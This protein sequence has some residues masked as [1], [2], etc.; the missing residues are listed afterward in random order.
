[1]TA[2]KARRAFLL[3]RLRKEGP[4][5]EALSSVL[6]ATAHHQSALTWLMHQDDDYSSRPRLFSLLFFSS[7][8]TSPT[9]LKLSPS[10]HP[11]HQCLLSPLPLSSH[12][13]V[14]AMSTSSTVLCWL[15]WYVTCCS[16]T[17]RHEELTSSNSS[18][19]RMKANAEHVPQDVAAEYYGQRATAGGLL[20]SEATYVAAKAGGQSQYPIAF[21]S[22]AD[23]SYSH[24][25]PKV[26]RTS[27]ASGTTLRLKDGAKLST[28]VSGFRGRARK[29]YGLTPIILG[30]SMPK[31]AR[32]RF[33]S[34]ISDVPL[35]RK[36]ST[37]SHPRRSASREA[38][39]RLAP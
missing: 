39:P 32:S 25:L 38:P 14:L 17:F 36:V 24:C 15:P 22:V 23:P 20:I 9:H 26:W 31:A 2:N 12:P 1:M 6:R 19:T 30:Q 29:D 18:Q 4:R 5:T 10:T 8:F 16:V 37:P 33:S 11:S 3:P 34:G 35:S 7:F 21:A 13:C 27:R 28:L